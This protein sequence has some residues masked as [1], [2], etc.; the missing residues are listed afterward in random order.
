MRNDRRKDLAV[1]GATDQ[2]RDDQGDDNAMSPEIRQ[3]IFSF[4]E[5]DSEGTWDPDAFTRRPLTRSD[6][7]AV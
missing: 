5:V 7:K 6:P 2:G 4:A 1:D 3:L